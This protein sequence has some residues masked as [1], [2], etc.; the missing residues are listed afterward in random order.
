MMLG[1]A[2]AT[3]LPPAIAL[4]RPIAAATPSG[5][6]VKGASG[7]GQDSGG[8]CVTRKSGTPRG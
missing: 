5:T 8:R 6:A 7:V 3:A 2:R 4:A 1:P